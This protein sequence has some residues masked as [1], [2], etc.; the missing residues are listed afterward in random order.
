MRFDLSNPHGLDPHINIET[1]K[2][3]NLYPGDQRMIQ[4]ENIHVFPRK[5]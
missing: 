1:F 5:I 2:P 3:R 4:I